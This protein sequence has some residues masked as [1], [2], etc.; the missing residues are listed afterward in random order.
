MTRVI[1]TILFTLLLLGACSKQ[2]PSAGMIETEAAHGQEAEVAKG[3]HGGRLLAD[4]EFQLELLI[5]ETNVEPEFRAWAWRGNTLVSTR[6]LQ[7]KVTLTRLDGQQDV[8]DFSPREDYLLGSGTVYEPHSF[9]VAVTS[10]HAGV[11]HAW[12]YD[13]FEG[14]TGI[15]DASA[16]AAGIKTERAG[17][18]TIKETL[19]L[20]GTVVPDPHR[21]FRIHPRF[22]GMVKAVKAA[23]GD[24]VRKGDEL[25][26]VEANDS[27]RTYSL[28]AP[29]AGEIVSRNVNTGEFVDLKDL[30]TLVDFSTVWVELAAFQH[31]LDRVKVGQQVTIKDADGHQGAVGLVKS[32]APVGSSASQS[33]TARV[34]LPNDDGLWR[35]GLFVSGD[36][37]VAEAEVAMA[38]RREAL[39]KFRDWTVVFE[40]VGNNY[41]IRP[42]TLG[43]M[44]E[45]WA[46]VLQGLAAGTEY[47]TANSYV[48]KADIEKSGA[49]HDH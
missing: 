14:R 30:L 16:Q 47:V 7:L 35:P 33:M 12:G 26:T 23:I 21:V 44:D 9:E 2:E 28:T 39:Q 43:R 25:V 46:E 27:L 15:S 40:K 5:F 37:Q 13:S 32:I 11:R 29:S 38:V 24:Q 45:Q 1:L 8:F 6:E 41:E 18:V 49:S 48:I 42:V 19:V 34:V 10:E 22:P 20:Q 3:P 31:D 4:G 17:P 36:V